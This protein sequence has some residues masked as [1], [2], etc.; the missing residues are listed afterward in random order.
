MNIA[1]TVQTPAT[2]KLADSVFTKMDSE[3]GHEWSRED[4]LDHV[5]E[6]EG[7]GFASACFVS[8]INNGGFDQWLMNG[9][10]VHYDCLY[11]L[12]SKML[13]V[14]H[15][16]AVASVR[17]ML[18]QAIHI[19]QVMNDEDGD[20]DNDSYDEVSNDLDA[21]DDTFYRGLG[22]LFQ[23]QVEAYLLNRVANSN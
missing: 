19:Q 17:R 16:N 20:T 6:L 10:N 7:Y 13:E 15:T 3:E 18:N 4:V 8:Q 11:T 9:Y 22:D 23:K 1:T 5:S 14:N 2:D 12:C 21:L